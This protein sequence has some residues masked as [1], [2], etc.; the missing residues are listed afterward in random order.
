MHKRIIPILI[1]YL[2]ALSRLQAQVDITALRKDSVIELEISVQEGW[3]LYGRA[4]GLEMPALVSGQNGVA[5]SPLHFMQSPESVQDKALGKNAWVYTGKLEATARIKQLPRGLAQLTCSFSGY[6]SNGEDFLPIDYKLRIPI[7]SSLG[8]TTRIRLPWSMDSD[9][10]G[11]ATQATESRSALSIFFLGFLGGLLALVTP[12]VFPMI[13]VTVSFFGSRSASRRK[14]IRLG[15]FYGTSIVAIYLLASAPFHL[16]SVKPELLNNIAT[17]AWLNILFF[18]VFVLFAVSFFGLFTLRLPS[19]LATKVDGKSN[20][21]SVAGIFFLALTLVIVSFSCTG[22]IL[23]SLLVGSAG[24]GGAWLLTA[25]CAGFGLALGLPFAVFAIFPQL[26][27]R[28]PQSGDW[29]SR[30]KVSLAFIELALAFKF[31]SNADLVLQWGLLKREVL[32]S[33][34][35]IIGILWIAYLVNLPWLIDYGKWKIRKSEAV[36]AAFVFASVCYLGFGVA[37][38]STPLLSGFAPPAFYSLR[39]M[40]GTKLEADVINDY[41]KAVTLAK[42]ENKKLLIDFT[43]WACVNC[44]KMEEQVWGDPAVSDYIKKHFVLVSLYVDDKQPLPAHQQVYDYVARDSTKRDILSLGDLHAA[45]EAE[46][47]GQVSQPLYAMVDSG[48]RLLGAPVGYTPDAD[49]FLRWLQTAA[50]NMA[51]N[52]N[53]R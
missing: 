36:V 27:K 38:K 33:I 18:I 26:L 6:A 8:S 5:L 20:T 28:L 9:I 46:N 24:V 39:E 17:S 37:G 44:R 48:E 14:A 23:G 35:L 10:A 2:A 47:L 31:L 15:M 21:G 53:E 25:G 1:A 49:T 45:M 42:K 52:K 29:L 22:P 41:E 32:L 34:W 50:V 40:K 30:V 43:G 11:R 51:Q 19:S 4:E 7:D 3:H 13:P 12:C 16:F